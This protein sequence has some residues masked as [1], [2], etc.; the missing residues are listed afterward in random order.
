M[1]REFRLWPL[2]AVVTAAAALT[3]GLAAPGVA[4]ASEPEF[5]ECL[6]VPN[7]VSGY[8]DS[9]CSEPNAEHKGPY[10]LRPVTHECFKTARVE[11]HYTG[12]W[13]DEEC[14]VPNAT[15]EGKYELKEGIAKG[16]EFNGTVTGLATFEV[17]GLTG[18]PFECTATKVSGLVT[19]AKTMSNVILTFTGCGL[20]HG[21][22]KCGSGTKPSTFETVPLSGTVGG[23]GES[24]TLT[25]SAS[26]GPIFE[27]G[28]SQVEARFR[29]SG[30]ITLILGPRGV[31]MVSK[32]LDAR[33][34][35]AI[36]AGGPLKFESESGSEWSEPIQ[37]ALRDETVHMKG[38]NLELKT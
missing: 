5:W 3:V 2:V 27:F 21:F 16:K 18:G 32:E 9:H 38:E 12:A 22:Y 1:S 28:C 34:E 17:E 29:F 31:G 11:K 25:L 23:A 15:H 37:A 19:G 36:F 33:A 8:N 30:S 13:E 24:P 14:T 10:E 20:L 35:E 6:K 7:K 4:S 26:G